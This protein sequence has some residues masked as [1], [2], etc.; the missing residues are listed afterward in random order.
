MYSQNIQEQVSNI[1]KEAR[2]SLKKQQSANKIEIEKPVPIRKT[3]TLKSIPPPLEYESAKK[4]RLPSGES[5]VVT[6][7]PSS[8]P[9][10]MSTATAIEEEV[11]IATE[12]IP[13][14][15]P[16]KKPAK[17]SGFKRDQVKLLL[18]VGFPE[19]ISGE[20]TKYTKKSY[21]LVIT[22][23]SDEGHKKQKTI[24]FGRKDHV[25]FIEHKDEARKRA[26]MSKLRKCTDMFEPNFYELHLLN[27][28]SVSLAENF[29]ALLKFLNL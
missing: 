6:P 26:E 13:E 16:P 29:T 21:R 28:H 4:L 5:Q 12:I 22:Y 27:G 15:V 20:R 19:K 3:V 7:M 18:T 14:Q 11:K 8:A 2:S 9:S 25:P 1:L 10:S 23:I 24:F 17:N